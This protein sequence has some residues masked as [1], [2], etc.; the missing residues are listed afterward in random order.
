M[1]NG[2]PTSAAVA[3]Q[4]SAT[5]R[6]L[7]VTE[8]NFLRAVLLVV[9]VVFLF[10]CG[11]YFEREIL[12]RH[13]AETRFIRE[14]TEAA[15][16]Y[17]TIPHFII[18]F[19][20]MVSSRRNQNLRQRMWVGG[21]LM[22]GTG[23]C[24]LYYLGGGK[25]NMIMYSAVYLYFLV[26]DLRDEA[27]FYNAL[28][29]SPSVADRATFNNFVRWMIGLVVF[30]LAALAWAPTPF[31]AYYEKVV[32]EQSAL[33]DTV[34]ASSPI[35]DGSLP[36]IAKLAVAGIPILIGVV[37]YALVLRYYA[38]R[39]GH[40]NVASLVNAHAPM[41]RVMIGVAAVLGLSLVITRRPY[42][43]I[44]FHVV[45]WY[46]FAAYQLAKHPPKAPPA[47]WWTWMRTTA[48]GFKTLHIGLVVLLMAVGLYWTLALD[49]ND[50]S[51]WLAAVL[52]PHAFLYWT[53][54]HITVSFVPR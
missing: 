24:A 47:G 51:H 19:L 39:L 38:A 22:L 28:G 2:H 23:L 17:L 1:A 6:E 44:L 9:G 12:N 43:L 27:M 26:H 18:G 29:D 35:Y 25:T 48:K 10:W 36:L 3:L 31:G 13:P 33:S 15:M 11:Y 41:I 52:H 42:A 30:S 16:R 46:V 50:T 53:I 7:T 21:L 32:A 5:R 37:C 20:F 4:P 54:M 14:S 40:P 34:L 8:R 49:P 45:A